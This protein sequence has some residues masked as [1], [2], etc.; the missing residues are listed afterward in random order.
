[1]QAYIIIHISKAEKVYGFLSIYLEK[2]D[3]RF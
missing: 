3:Q 1:M 2:V